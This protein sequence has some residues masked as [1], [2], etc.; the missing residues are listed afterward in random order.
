MGAKIFI[1]LH[2]KASTFITSFPSR[3][4]GGAFGLEEGFG[5]TGG[6]E[7]EDEEL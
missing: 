1:F 2:L 3:A 4:A 7:T 5:V 6:A